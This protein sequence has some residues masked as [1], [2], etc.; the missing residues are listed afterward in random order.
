M[1]AKYSDRRMKMKPT[2]DLREDTGF[3]RWRGRGNLGCEVSVE[4]TRAVM[5]GGGGDKRRVG[6]GTGRKLLASEPAEIV[7]HG[8]IDN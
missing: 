8:R 1:R 7:S 5:K 2:S 4:L 3:N 6:S